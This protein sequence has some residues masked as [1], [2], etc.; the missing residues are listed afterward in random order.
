[1]T[2]YKKVGRVTHLST[3][4]IAA[5]LLLVLAS[6]GCLANDKQDLSKRAGRLI[7]QGREK[8][9]DLSEQATEKIEDVNHVL[10]QK[11]RKAQRKARRFGQRIKDKAHEVGAA[12]QEKAHVVG[13]KIKDTAHDATEAIRDYWHDHVSSSNSDTPSRASA[14]PAHGVAEVSPH[15]F[16]VY[17]ADN[18]VII[19]IDHIPSGKARGY[20]DRH[21]R[22][23]V[24]EVQREDGRVTKFIVISK[25][26]SLTIN[27]IEQKGIGKHKADNIL[28]S[29]FDLAD[30]EH[31]VD[32]KAHHNEYLPLHLDVTKATVDYYAAPRTMF[33]VIPYIEPSRNGHQLKINEK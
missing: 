22:T 21:T 30:A 16:I 3:P 10:R 11:A 7:Q 29:N 18:A 2:I 14:A 32:Y 20:V 4:Y 23:V 9:E 27:E 6:S 24:V 1:M 25:G 17:E 15:E 19:Q 13:Q 8:A 5:S 28:A 33:I 12:I 26:N 31:A